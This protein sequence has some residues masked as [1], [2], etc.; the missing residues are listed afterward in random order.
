MEGCRHSQGTGCNRVHAG[1]GRPIKVPATLASARELRITGALS[2]IPRWRVP[3][4]A[5]GRPQAVLD[6][7]WDA[8]EAPRPRT[9]CASV[10]GACARREGQIGV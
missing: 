4:A 1:H 9:R 8:R 10:C 5:L 3:G 2:P 7:G 6:Q